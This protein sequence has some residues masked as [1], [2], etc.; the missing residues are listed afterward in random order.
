MPALIRFE[1]FSPLQSQSALADN[2]GYDSTQ[3]KRP[4]QPIRAFLDTHPRI[5][6]LNTA[7]PLRFTLLSLF[8]T[9]RFFHPFGFLRRL[10]R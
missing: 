3:K 8:H 5:P 10:L 9:S 2:N 4:H 6:N 7:M 1:T